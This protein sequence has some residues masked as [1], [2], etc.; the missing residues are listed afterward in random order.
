MDLSL[1]G[2]KSLI[3][4]YDLLKNTITAKIKLY[5]LKNKSLD[6]TNHSHWWYNVDDNLFSNSVD[7]AELGYTYLGTHNNNIIKNIASAINA[8]VR[9]Y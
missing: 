7:E 8:E 9:K 2:I 6:L 5:L 4:N 1:T 3:E